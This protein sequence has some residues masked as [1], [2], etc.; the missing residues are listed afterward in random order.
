MKRYFLILAAIIMLILYFRSDK[1]YVIEGDM[2]VGGEKLP[3]KSYFAD[4][5]WRTEYINSKGGYTF[6]YNGKKFYSYS[7]DS[8]SVKSFNFNE[9]D[10][11]QRNPINPLL[12]W[13]N[14]GSVTTR[15]PNGVSVNQKVTSK[16]TNINGFD[17]ILIN[18]SS[19]RTACVSEE[20]GF[21]V[22]LK[23]NQSVLSVNSIEP[24]KDRNVFKLTRR[25]KNCESKR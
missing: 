5:K 25:I 24:L 20:Y 14:G 1:G 17:C 9:N 23:H 15:I 11:Q 10:I 2:I 18:L 22:Y 12:N 8:K 13:R 19:S 3:F 6:L 16:R 4:K 7:S 21:A